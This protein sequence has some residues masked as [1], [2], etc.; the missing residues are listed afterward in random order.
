MDLLRA[1]LGAATL[2]RWLTLVALV[3]LFSA[4][5][6]CAHPARLVGESLETQLFDRANAPRRAPQFTPL[7][8][9]LFAAWTLASSVV[10][11][12]A[13]LDRTRA[14]LLP[15][16][17]SFVIALLFFASEVLVFATVSPSA[18]ARPAIVAGVSVL[19]IA[20]ELQRG[21]K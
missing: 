4:A 16:L 17:A 13:A 3:R 12:A 11:A 8:A 20:H 1:L 15:C 2:P 18:A 9:R 14:T 6:G 19:W 7:A 21:Q 5:L 10:C